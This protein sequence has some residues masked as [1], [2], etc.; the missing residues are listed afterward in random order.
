[1]Q[2]PEYAKRRVA[3]KMAV[4]QLAFDFYLMLLGL[5]F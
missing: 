4:K 1:L 5:L 2:R 3:L